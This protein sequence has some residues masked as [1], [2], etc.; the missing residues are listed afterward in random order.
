MLLDAPLKTLPVIVVASND[1]PKAPAAP[2]APVD[3]TKALADLGSALEDLKLATE[4]VTTAQEKLDASVQRV[5]AIGRVREMLISQID[6]AIVPD[7][8]PENENGNGPDALVLADFTAALRAA[9]TDYENAKKDLDTAESQLKSAVSTAGEKLGVAAQE[10]KLGLAE[11]ALDAKLKERSYDAL[12]AAYQT[13]VNKA[14]SDL[15]AKKTSMDAK[16]LEVDN[17]TAALAALGDRVKLVSARDTAQT[18]ADAA[19]NA[20]SSAVKAF[21]AHKAVYDGYDSAF[22][23]CGDDAMCTDGVWQSQNAY[24][25]DYVAPAQD[26]AIA[27]NVSS[28]QA[29]ND[30][31]KAKAAVTDFDNKTTDLGTAS[32]DLVPLKEAY[33][34]A[35]AAFEKADE[36]LYELTELKKA[37]D[38]ASSTLNETWNEVDGDTAVIEANQ[39]VETAQNTLKDA[40]AKANDA[41][42]GSEAEA[43]ALQAVR[44]AQS[45]LEKA[46]GAQSDAVE[47]AKIVVAEA[48]KVDTPK[49][50][51]ALA[52]MNLALEDAE[53]AD[54]SG[55]AADE[56]A[57]N[58][59]EDHA[60][61]RQDLSD[62]LHEDDN[63]DMDTIPDE[64]DAT[65][66]EVQSAASEVTQQAEVSNTEGS[67]EAAGGEASSSESGASQSDGSEGSS[68]A[69]G[70]SGS[71]TS[72]SETSGSETGA[73]ESVPAS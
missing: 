50:D 18:K 6:I 59:K 58:A 49:V 36:D 73:A 10:K 21:E 32:A 15:D 5:Q 19:S 47:A 25:D 60:D 13:E 28:N 17:L 44:D 1:G 23:E 20:Y 64:N 40:I 4:N 16:Q 51:A 14:T 35:E 65:H 63:L 33:E 42:R 57:S 43:E 55:D 12:F 52:D 8:D 70:T 27:A 11:D 71:E 9:L 7:E 31:S 29:T 48:I 24:W 3:D 67:T 54:K 39:A 34:T 41:V 53:K 46:L 62:A 72:G 66:P 45:D 30:L 56:A 22:E 68:D 2:A 37:V 61:A 69:S 38:D 26:K